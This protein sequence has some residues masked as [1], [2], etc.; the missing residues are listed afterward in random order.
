MSIAIT[1]TNGTATTRHFYS[2]YECEKA[3]RRFVLLGWL[4]QAEADSYLNNWSKGE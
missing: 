3:M 4:T 2:R 1:F